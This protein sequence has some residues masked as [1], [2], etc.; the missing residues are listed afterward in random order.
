MN[1]GTYHKSGLVLWFTGL[2]GAGKTTIAEGVSEKLKKRSISSKIIDG[3]DVRKNKNVHLGFSEGDI[4]L[5][6]KLIAD[7]CVKD[8]LLFD[9]ILV[10]IISPYRISRT[11]ARAKLSSGFYEIHIDA[12][13]EC[14]KARDVK[15]L[16]AKVAMRQINN[17]IGIAHSNPYEVPLTPDVSIMTEKETI[18]QSVTKICD[19]ILSKF[20]RMVAI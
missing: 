12:S 8:R 16:Y 2:S 1:K 15:G 19:F 14:V 17:M 10:P 5:N 4:K 11:E 18:D 3:D 13:I 20:G 6:N 9:V 7:M